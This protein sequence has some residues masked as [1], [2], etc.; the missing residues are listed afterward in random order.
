M[1]INKLACALTALTFLSTATAAFAD[2][3]VKLAVGQR[4]NWDTSVSEVGQLAG[5]ETLAVQTAARTVAD[6]PG[7]LQPAASTGLPWG[8]LPPRARGQAAAAE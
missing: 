8:H 5:N 1:K 3:T 7:Q 4:G 6:V 2:D